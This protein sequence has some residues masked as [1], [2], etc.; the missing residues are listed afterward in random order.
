MNIF[1]KIGCRL[2]QSVLYVGM[3]FM[4]FRQPKLLEGEGAFENTADYMR[5]LN[6]FRPLVVCD[7]AALERKA[8]QPFFD[9]AQGKLDYFVY[10]GVLPNPTVQQVEEGLAVYKR[11]NCDG[12]LAFG[13]GS[14]MDCAKAIG[15]RVVRPKK[16][17]NKMKGLLKVGKKL[18]P[19]FAVP[20]TAGTGSECTVAAVITDGETHDKYAINDFSLIPHYAVLDP[21]LTSSLLPHLTA[22]T[23][24]DALTHAVEA[25]IGR[26]NTRSTKR[27]AEE[28]VKLIFGNLREATFNGSN[29]DA[30]MNMQKAAYLAGLAFTR[31]YVG[32]VHALAHA[33]GG[34]YGIAHGY[35]NAVLLPEVLK[36]YGKSAH[37]KLA[38]L[39]YVSGIADKNDKVS[40]AANKFICAIDKMNGDLSISS[41]F[42]GQIKEED[43]DSLAKHAAKEANPL[44]PVPKL[45]NSNEL[46]Q[47]YFKVA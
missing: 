41:A 1:G 42:E 16:S 34:T 25:Y 20:T 14:A 38:K 22:T 29:T 18:P 33:L 9:G 15:A 46:K 17:V 45:M 2:Y 4:P 40:V 10:D 12:I 23:G 47:I 19:L 26:G 24:M 32:Y 13:G 44:Y 27:Q 7:K 11:N 31:A 37:K 5:S 35:A 8:L 21:L 39:A 43:F 36:A 6:V 30:R 28:A 3:A